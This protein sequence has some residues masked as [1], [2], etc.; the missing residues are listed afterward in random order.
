[1]GEV[2]AVLV[3]AGFFAFIGFKFG[4]R[5]EREANTGKGGPGGGGIKGPG[6]HQK[7]K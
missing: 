2:I 3:I 4:Q 7:R 5:S 6:D 1:M